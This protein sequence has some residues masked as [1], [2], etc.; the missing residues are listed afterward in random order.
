MM[1]FAAGVADQ[2]SEDDRVDG[3]VVVTE[4]RSEDLPRGPMQLRPKLKGSIG[5]GSNHSNFSH[6]SS[7]K[8]QC[9]LLEK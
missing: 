9:I 5:E 3:A 7:V 2:I 1:N 4:E 6:Q 8:I